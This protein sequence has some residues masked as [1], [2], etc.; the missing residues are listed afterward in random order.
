MTV[1]NTSRRAGPLLGN[2]ATTSWPFSFKV[3]E[4]TDIQVVV[5]NSAGAETTLTYGAH[6]SVTLNGDQDASPGGSVTYPLSGAA[7]PSGS[8]LVIAGNLPYTQ[9]LDLP[10]GGPFNAIS[11]ENAHDRHV[12][13]IQQL[14]EQ[15]DRSLHVS[16]TSSID[17]ELPV[18]EAG[19]ALVWND[20]EDAL[21]NADL[22][23]LDLGV[24]Y[25][26]WDYDIF[27]GTGAQTAFT[28]SG[29][30]VA[31]SATFVS[32]D[33]ATKRPVTDYTLSGNVVTFGAAPGN[34]TSI[35]VRYGTA[36]QQRD[37]YQL[38]YNYTATGGQTVFSVPVG[39]AMG[40]NALAVYANGL[41]L[42]PS[43]DYTETST[44]SIT[45]ASG[46]TLG[47]KV[48]IV[49]GTEQLGIGG[50][51]DTTLSTGIRTV[52]LGDSMA[53]T[54]SFLDPSWPDAFAQRMAALG[55]R[56]D[57]HNLA[58][59]GWTFNKANTTACFGAQTMLQRAIA[60]SPDLVIVALGANDLILNIE[61]RS[62]A[63]VQAD[64]ASLFSALRAALPQAVIVYASE[65][66]YD[67]TNFTPPSVKNKGVPVYFQQKKTGGSYLSGIIDNNYS[68]E[69]LDDQAQSAIRTGLQNWVTVDTYIKSLAD[70]DT[71]FTL[72]YF[73]AARLGLVG[74][75][76]LH[77]TALG[78]LF[79]SGAAVKAIYDDADSAFGDL[80]PNMMS[81]DYTPWNSPDYVFTSFLSA[82]GDGYVAAAYDLQTVHVSKHAGTWGRIN[83]EAWYTPSKG[84]V[85]VYPTTFTSDDFSIPFWAITNAR[86][87]TAVEVSTNGAAFSSSGKG[88]DNYG[89][90][91]FPAY[92]SFLA[93]GSYTFRYRVGNEV[94]GPISVTVTAASEPQLNVK[95][96]AEGVVTTT[97][98]DTYTTCAFDTTVTNTGGGTYSAG[99]YTIPRAGRYQV[100]AQV[101]LKDLPA[102]GG[103]FLVA[104]INGTRTYDGPLHYNISG[105]AAYF[106]AGIAFSRRF[107]VGDTVQ[108]K[109]YQYGAGNLT[110]S[111]GTAGASAWM[112]ISWIGS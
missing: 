103:T 60:L 102:N 71:D 24:V 106:G 56:V 95:L 30:P 79:L 91:I 104:Y 47:D 84:H 35:L 17:T 75:D 94:F 58:K 33:G 45:M 70:I 69:Y 13:L 98:S 15:Q 74:V 99:T 63:Q 26:D 16:I 11:A 88:T 18:P 65:L 32:V 92:G 25:A 82:S 97:G 5:R 19:K 50:G 1:S 36:V 77:L 20:D 100:N 22:S 43:D 48:T 86:P 64:A 49:V 81:Q 31:A 109:L 53:A 40:E 21:V 23:D 29:T 78:Q 96:S 80:F 37:A 2:G 57:L 9:T 38:V 12:M 39:Y 83:P 42:T 108:L 85:D 68:S 111:P 55:A 41:R 112:N 34:G 8:S 107:S 28:L 89:N 61:G 10:D 87:N 6:Y 93:A 7:L 44:T 54:N 3:F 76:G 105:G 27:S 101:A 73:N 52:V 14:R 72:P 67:S 51:G 4:A 66:M 62:N 59:N 90:A 110:M 46:L